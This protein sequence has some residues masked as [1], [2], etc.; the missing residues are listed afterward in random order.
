M[1]EPEVSA[2]T[3]AQGTIGACTIIVC[4]VVLSA[5]G[6]WEMTAEA[7]LY[8]LFARIFSET[9]MFTIPDRSPLYVLY[10]NLFTWIGYPTSVTVQYLV[11]GTFAI[12]SI[13]VL[14]RKF[15]GLRMAVFA[16]LLW[17]PYLLQFTESPVLMMSLGVACL[18]V[19][20]RQNGT[21]RLHL[22]TSY[23]LF[24][25]AAMLRPTYVVVIG[26]FAVWDTTK[27][28]KKN[29]LRTLLVGIRP[30]RADWPVGVVLMLFIWFTAMQS[31]HPL[32]NVWA[33]TTTKWLLTDGKS[34]VDSVFIQNSN[35]AYISRRY[36]S[37]EGKDLYFTNREI[38]GD[39]TTIAGAIRTN[40][41]YVIEQTAINITR[42]PGALL[43]MT[44][45]PRVFSSISSR[46]KERQE[47]FPLV[48]LGLVYLTLSIGIFYGAFRAARDESMILFLVAS[49]ALTGMTS[50][51]SV[52]VRWM[53]A[54][55]PILLLSAYWY[56]E[57]IRQWFTQRASKIIEK[58]GKIKT[59]RWLG[60]FAGLWSIPLSLA[61]LSNGLSN[62]KNIISSV[63][64]DLHQ[65]EVHVME[66]KYLA[67]M[68]AS[69]NI[70]NPLIRSCKGV[71]TL[72][73]AFVGAFADVPVEQVHSIWE[74]PPFGH[75]DSSGYDGLRPD[76]IDCVLVSE[77][78]SVEVGSA[79]N[80]KIR[81][82]NYIR[83]YVEQLQKMGA[84]TY[85]VPH[86]GKVVI[87]DMQS[88]SSMK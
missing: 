29:G 24:G 37:F 9:Y 51:F 77:A 59:S 30:R 73:S 42:L 56:G 72:E 25:V 40:P 60:S 36:G 52:K 88:L 18:A 2:R 38:F 74:I 13:A 81:Y 85:E 27:I 54:M 33:A 41:G 10:L 78:L 50:L 35:I 76:R 83:P 15:F 1:K 48:L 69:F 8:W 17:I 66:Q 80:I 34:L 44:E 45:F 16:V 47:S 32:N 71:M 19:V 4:A 43:Q 65:G 20:T 58:R 79:T 87:L 82:E 39:A 6:R 68:K 26:V 14:F 11:S 49:I 31:P 5:L 7:W 3:S 61:I 67:S 64:G 84:V 70:W 28:L 55:V 57:K 62:W 46:L 75:F 22:A 53:Y 21:S 23:A 86:F 12:G 63:A